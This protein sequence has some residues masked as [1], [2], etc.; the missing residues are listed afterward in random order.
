MVSLVTAVSLCGDYE[1]NSD[2]LLSLLKLFSRGGAVGTAGGEKDFLEFFY[3]LALSD[4]LTYMSSKS[5]K[6]LSS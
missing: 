6:D 4:I 1:I 2:R 5:F 3:F